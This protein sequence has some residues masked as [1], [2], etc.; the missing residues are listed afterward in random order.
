MAVCVYLI[1]CDWVDST[2]IQTVEPGVDALGLVEETERRIAFDVSDVSE[3]DDT[4]Q[5]SWQTQE[6]GALA[7][8][9]THIDLTN[10][11][12]SLE[13]ACSP[14]ESDCSI[15]FVEDAAS[16]ND[17]DNQ[18]GYTVFPPALS[19]PVGVH[20][21]WA[22]SDG[23]ET[24][25]TR[26]ISLCVDAVNAAPVANEDRFVVFDGI[27]EL[28][29]EGHDNELCDALALDNLLSNDLDDRHLGNACVSVEL[30]DLPEYATND[31][32]A[33]FGNSGGFRYTPD[34]FRQYPEDTFSYRLFDGELYSEVA[35]VT[36]LIASEFTEPDA[37]ADSFTVRRNSEDNTLDPL[38]NDD[39][40]ENTTMTLIALSQPSAGGQVSFTE[41][42]TL[43]YTP[44]PGFIGFDYFSYTIE[45]E[46]RQT[47]S[48]TIRI[49][50][51]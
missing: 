22:I 29:I 16:G 21:Q 34:F 20:Y 36:V 17:D 30:V 7:A 48:A 14:T 11:S 40:P 43:S 1:G 50:V 33:E 41:Q 42:N 6:E 2:G 28:V 46:Y 25:D 5:Y 27:D 23:N 44:R 31:F 8:C 26:E 9:A 19:R 45:N 18:I 13:E 35:T 37:S 15:I 12:A 47:D 32:S 49:R 38:Q 39:D 3:P 51:R 10:A 4:T 24:L